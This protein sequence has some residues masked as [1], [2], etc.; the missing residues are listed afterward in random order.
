[1]FSQVGKVFPS[2]AILLLGIELLQRRLI[3][4]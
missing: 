2:R 3:N 1:M 4:L